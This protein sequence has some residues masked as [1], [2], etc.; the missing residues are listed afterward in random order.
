MS[1]VA[2]LRYALGDHHTYDFV[3]G[4]VNAEMHPAIRD[5]F[6]PTDA[7]F[8]YF[9][10]NDAGSC[11]KAMNDLS[12]FI[13]VEGP[14]DGVIAFSQGASVAATLMLHRLRQNPGHERVSPLF[15]CAIFLGAA[16]PCD[17]AELEAGRIKEMAY[18]ADGEV[19]LVPTTHIWGKLDP[20]V[21]PSS[22][23]KLCSEDQRNIYVHVGGHEIPGSQ[24]HEALGESV[25]MIKRSISM[26]Q[27]N[28]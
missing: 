5:Y 25:R 21:Y 20:S 8:K 11:L 24:M 13:A 16:V 1:N 7:Y 14:F 9:E 12:N 26:A 22:L 19:I 3:E 15:S 23:A 10:E 28:Q 2:A 27:Y 4:V 18:E 17:P 6:S